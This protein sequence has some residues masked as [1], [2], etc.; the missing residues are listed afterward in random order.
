[1]Q[2]SEREYFHIEPFQPEGSGF[3]KTIENFFKGT[4]E[5]WNNFFKP[6]LIIVTPNISA[7]LAAKT[8]N[9]QSSEGTSNISVSLTGGRV[10]NLTDLHG[11]GLRLKL[12]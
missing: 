4:E 5:L 3:E 11:N 6:G 2:I 9:P 10:L 8:N 7:G 1:M 12:M